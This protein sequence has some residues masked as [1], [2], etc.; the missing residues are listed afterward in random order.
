[1]HHASVAKVE[2]SRFEEFLILENEIKNLDIW[3]EQKKKELLDV[4]EENY[5]NSINEWTLTQLLYNLMLEK[6]I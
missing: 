2:D 6:E 1:M 5:K 3:E 4:L